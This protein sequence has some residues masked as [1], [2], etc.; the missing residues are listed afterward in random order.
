MDSSK[1]YKE[2][3]KEALEQY[4]IGKRK[5][6]DPG[7]KLLNK[8]K[9]IFL[10]L[11]VYNAIGAIFVL[12]CLLVF[13]TQSIPEEIENYIFICAFLLPVIITYII[14]RKIARNFYLSDYFH[15]DDEIDI[16]M[17]NKTEK[18]LTSK[19]LTSKEDDK[20]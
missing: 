11:L 13:E 8:T 12:S 7:T 9:K 1:Y 3:Y 6:L 5:R 19:E 15:S 20:R 4:I 10:A 2:A 14:I 17:L 16:A 18:E